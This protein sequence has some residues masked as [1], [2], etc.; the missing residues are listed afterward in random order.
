MTPARPTAAP[1]LAALLA[2]VAVVLT[3]AAP[4]GTAGTAG[5]LE[6]PP[7]RFAPIDVFVDAGE[8]R[9]G[10]WQLELTPKPEFAGSVRIVGIAGGELPFADPPY[11]DP[12]ALAD[13]ERVILA[14]FEVD[15]GTLNTGRSR[16]AQ[17]QLEITSED[18]P[19][20]EVRLHSAMRH[21]GALIEAAVEAVLRT[22]AETAPTQE[23]P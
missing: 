16:V 23:T 3:A 9:L 11:Y 15:A 14:D 7:V 18:N 8:E 4:A 10:A 6:A 20:F 19:E 22:G 2:V 17:V 5:A 1:W 13:G 21:D 12:A